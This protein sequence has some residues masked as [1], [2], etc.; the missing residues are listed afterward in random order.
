MVPP[1]LETPICAKKTR[2]PWNF[3][4]PKHFPQ[5]SLKKAS[6]GPAWKP[7]PVPQSP[8][9]HVAAP[10]V[11]VAYCQSP[12]QSRLRGHPLLHCPLWAPHCESQN[13]WAGKAE[14][15]D[16]RFNWRKSEVGTW[17]PLGPLLKVKL[18]VGYRYPLVVHVAQWLIGELV[19]DQHNLVKTDKSYKMMGL[20]KLQIKQKKPRNRQN[21]RVTKMQH[22]ELKREMD[23]SPKSH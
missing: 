20:Q 5:K 8:K 4:C 6:M 2:L 13:A 1:C 23:D 17:Q 12:H 11:S 7:K 22:R 3:W 9:R 19:S 15:S 21:H 14:V 16:R 10:V 18:L